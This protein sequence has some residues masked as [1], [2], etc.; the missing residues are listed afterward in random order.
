[1]CTEPN[2][3]MSPSRWPDEPRS[4]TEMREA[5]ER[6]WFR[7]LIPRPDLRALV[8]AGANSLEAF[9]RWLPYRQAFAPQL[10]REFLRSGVE[11]PVFDP[12]A[13]AGTGMIECSRAGVPSHGIEALASLA[14]LARARGESRLPR[15]PDLGGCMTWRDVADRLELTV[16]RAALVLAVCR[17]YDADG[18]SLREPLPLPE[19]LLE[20]VRMM[21]ED[22][23][24]PL[25]LPVQ[26]AQGDARD[27]SAIEESSLGALL[28]SPPYL[29]R[30]DYTRITR[31]HELVYRHWYEAQPLA[32]R[33]QAQLRAHP[34]A[35]SQ[36]WSHPTHSAV[37][38]IVRVFQDRGRRKTAGIVRS[39][40]DDLH[41]VMLEFARVVRP[42]GVAWIVIGGSRVA[43]VIIPADAILAEIAGQ[44]GWEVR[45]LWE[46]RRLISAGR[47]LGSLHDIAPRESVL[48]LRRA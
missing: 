15:L 41:A 12:F 7:R 45:G 44:C 25:A 21:R 2:P 37:G 39:Y 10:V 6:R 13:G 9:H 3:L 32:R 31:A 46:A 16:H 34:R 29:S 38:E 5:L 17:Q 20:V 24:Q 19:L 26:V 4:D 43:G 35:H 18:N 22:L 48:V 23:A 14:F 40:F 30:H 28:T 8:V 33:R 36:T 1:M 47:R 11:P 42:G 27:L